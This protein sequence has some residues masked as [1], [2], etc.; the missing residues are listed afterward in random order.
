MDR[1][2]EKRRNKKGKNWERLNDWKSNGRIRETYD[3]Q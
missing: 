1:N 2:S 3:P